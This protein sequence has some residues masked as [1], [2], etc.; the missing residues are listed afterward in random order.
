MFIAHPIVSCPLEII[1]IAF[2]CNLHRFE[3]LPRYG[4]FDWRLMP[5]PQNELHAL[6]RVNL[7]W[8]VFVQERSVALA[9]SISG[10]VENFKVC[11]RLFL[12]LSKVAN[13]VVQGIT[14][15]LPLASEEFSSVRR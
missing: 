13:H 4:R 3:H 14:T 11:T 15:F 6:E 8:S 5:P 12:P 7:W 1:S 9:A 10:A 2:A